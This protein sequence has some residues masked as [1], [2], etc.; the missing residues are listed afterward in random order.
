MMR[1]ILQIHFTYYVLMGYT[2]CHLHKYTIYI[3]TY[4]IIITLNKLKLNSYCCD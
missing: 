4:F 2:I 3:K 1:F